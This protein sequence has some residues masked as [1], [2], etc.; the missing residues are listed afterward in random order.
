MESK[1]SESF[2]NNISRPETQTVKESSVLSTYKS[3]K[4]FNK[5]SRIK[6]KQASKSSLGSEDSVATDKKDASRVSTAAGENTD[7]TKSP[8][9]PQIIQE[10]IF[11]ENPTQEP[12]NGPAIDVKS[13]KISALPVRPLMLQNVEVRLARLKHAQIRDIQVTAVSDN[14]HD[15]EPDDDIEIL[16]P[17]NVAM[18]KTVPFSEPITEPMIIPSNQSK[19]QV[20]PVAFYSADLQ[21]RLKP[22][23]IKIARLKKRSYEAMD[24]DASSEPEIISK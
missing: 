19:S 8:H 14:T 10:N 1:D 9:Q 21:A 17:Q 6:E 15:N 5:S 24:S 16:E 20:E 2:K 18:P 22:C 12:E 4:Y 3:A 7:S 13:A 11:S 23:D